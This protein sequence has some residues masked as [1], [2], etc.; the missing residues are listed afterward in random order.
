M[1][2][3]QFTDDDGDTHHFEAP[4]EE[5]AYKVLAL[6]QGGPQEEGGGPCCRCCARAV[7]Y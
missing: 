3:F 6:L 5:S 4:N 2:I 1:P 7:I